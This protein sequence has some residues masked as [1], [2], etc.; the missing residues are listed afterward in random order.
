MQNRLRPHR[1]GSCDHRRIRVSEY[2][3][4]TVANPVFGDHEHGLQQ[5]IA[6]DNV[7]IL[8][9]PANDHSYADSKID[10][11]WYPR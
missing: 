5:R 3:E 2:P 8:H 6:T 4:D 10:Y 7:K 9:A 11:G 1:A